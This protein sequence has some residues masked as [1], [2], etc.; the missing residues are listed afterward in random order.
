MKLYIK[1]CDEYPLH[2]LDV[3]DWLAKERGYDTQATGTIEILYITENAYCIEPTAL[4]NGHFSYRDWLPKNQCKIVE[5]TGPKQ[6][7]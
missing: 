4:S 1:P 3:T 6:S 7:E 5:R 2:E